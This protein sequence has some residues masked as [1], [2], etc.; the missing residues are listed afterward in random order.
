MTTKKLIYLG[1]GIGLV[2]YFLKFTKGGANLLSKAL[3]N[4]QVITT[5]N[6]NKVVCGTPCPVG[7]QLV[8][9]ENGVSTCVPQICPSGQRNLVLPNG[10]RQCVPEDMLLINE[11]KRFQF[12][13]SYMAH[14][15]DPVNPTQDNVTS[16]A[17]GQFVDG[18]I[19]KHW[20]LLGET[21]TEFL[22]IV[23]RTDGTIPKNATNTGV[24]GGEITVFIPADI[25]TE[26]TTITPT[27][28]TT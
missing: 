28:T 9:D 24:W 16:F 20:D 1:A 25:V 4:C 17:Q 26:V 3:P 7:K 27:P 8:T 2:Y 13:N 22:R 18:Y 15:V 14:W 21:P 5:Q 11:P 19:Q 12:L 23:T 6:R 10:A